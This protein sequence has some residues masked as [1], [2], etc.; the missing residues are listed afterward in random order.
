M[1]Y[2][3]IINEKKYGQYNPKIT[4]KITAK[5]MGR[6]IYLMNKY[7]G[8]KEFT[9]H[10]CKNRNKEDGDDIHYTYK[11]NIEPT[12]EPPEELKTSKKE[13][14]ELLNDG[15]EEEIYKNNKSIKLKK[16]IQ[17]YFKKMKDKKMNK[18]KYILQKYLIEAKKM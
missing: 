2:Q 4:P 14:D 16:Y 5:K 6:M 18:T 13:L 7:D 12:P 9:I 11:I 10:F 1:V 8:H 3:L 15:K 17:T